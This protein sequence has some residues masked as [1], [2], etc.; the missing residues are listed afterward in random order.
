MNLTE[1]TRAWW[2]N[3][4]MIWFIHDEV[5]L[6][7]GLEKEYGYYQCRRDINNY[8]Q[9]AR[10]CR[11]LTK[12]ATIISLPL[13]MSFCNETLQLFPSR[14]GV[15]FCAS[16]G[17]DWPY[18]LFWPTECR[19]KS[20]TFWSLGL[21]KLCTLL[22]SFWEPIYFDVDKPRVAFWMIKEEV[23]SPHGS[24]WQPANCQMYK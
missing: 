12:L 23:Q 14:D 11:L 3:E 6:W 16:Q 5:R 13:P 21:E 1:I 20:K 15:H 7:G 2:M 24:S 8:D 10:H 17:E 19:N 22:L 18:D 9:K 4:W